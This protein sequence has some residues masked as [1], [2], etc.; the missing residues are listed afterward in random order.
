[1]DCLQMF[2]PRVFKLAAFMADMPDVFIAA[3]NFSFSLV[4]RNIMC[5]GISD[6]LFS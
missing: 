4:D 1:M 6:Q 5:L 3:V 2:V